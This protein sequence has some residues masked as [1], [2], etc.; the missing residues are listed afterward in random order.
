MPLV[1]SADVFIE[2]SLH[3]LEVNPSSTRISITYGS[4]SKKQSKKKSSKVTKPEVENRSFVS[5]KTFDPISGQLHKLKTF[6]TKELSKLLTAL[7]PHGVV[8]SK[9]TIKDSKEQVTIKGFSTILAN[10]EVKEDIEPE[11]EK[12]KAADQP[13]AGTSSKKN[14]KKKGK[15]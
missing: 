10:T 1:K 13:A 15:R 2:R 12:P 7:G 11:V 3:L 5:F 9:P 8:I 6:K 14:K 4:E